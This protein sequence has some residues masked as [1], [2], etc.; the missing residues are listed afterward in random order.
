MDGVFSGV[1]IIEF[2]MFVAGPYA[3]EMFAH[4][5]ADVIKVEPVSG[6][7]TRFNSTI[8]PGEGRAYI[9][10]AR[11]KRGLPLNL[12]HEQGRAIAR[13][14]ALQ[15]DVLISN[16][17]PGLLKRLGLD[18]ESLSAENPRIIVGE[19]SAMGPEGPYGNHA[20]ADFQASAAS[21]LMLASASF[22]GEEARFVD[23]FPSDFMA[24][25][26]LAFGIASALYRREHSGR[27]Q[28]V[29]TS[30]YQAGLAVQHATANVFDAV[31]G[32]KREYAQ[33]MQDER[34][35]PREAAARR[36]RQSPVM[37]GGLYQTKDDR[38]ITLGSS[39]RAFERLLDIL[40]LDDPSVSDPAWEMPDDPH[41]HFAAL[42]RRIRAVVL[43]FDG[44]DLR[45]RLQQAGV[46]CSLLESLEEAMLGEHARAN[47]FV[48]SWDH[49]T[50]GPVTMAQAP[51]S[52]SADHYSAA[53]RTPAFGEHLRE[54]LT[55]LGYGDDEIDQLIADGAVAEQLP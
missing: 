37:V 42:R 43:R 2:G 51:L 19:I 11:G 12:R 46:P 4:G 45:Q 10:K 1:R 7:A 39:K 8:V 44:E 53:E 3:S 41:E 5:G 50:V 16:M 18:Y 47:G 33:W 34:P 26:L 24:G 52:F 15:S 31:D 48:H 40:G 27:G 32:W 20:G 55:E 25:T 35:H 21:G 9:I 17:R 6:D 54:L 30:L 13:R 29:R 38:W 49:P 36:R 23:A 22:E 14:L 28:H